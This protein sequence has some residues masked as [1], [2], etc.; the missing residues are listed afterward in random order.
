[1]ETL[2][3]YF[4]RIGLLDYDA[5]PSV[6]A[7][8]KRQYRKSYQKEYQKKFRKNNVRKDIYFSPKEFN[9]LSSLARKNKKPVS[10]FCKDLIF[11]YLD[12]HFVLPDD[13]TVR[14]LELFLRGA[15][16]NLNQLVRYI[17]QRKELSYQDISYLRDRINEMENMISQSLRSPDDLR[18]YLEKVVHQNPQTIS[19]LETVLKTYKTDD[20]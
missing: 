9:R 8:A 16:N 5:T 19:V 20:N 6:I 7:E 13:E 1:M 15:T 10:R 11:A 12:K 17:H 2:Y 18:E 4:Q 14:Q 3:E